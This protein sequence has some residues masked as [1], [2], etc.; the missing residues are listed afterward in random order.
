MKSKLSLIVLYLIVCVANGQESKFGKTSLKYGI[1]VGVAD[2]IQVTGD[3]GLFFCGLNQQIGSRD[4]FRFSPQLSLG[5][6]NSNWIT[7]V[8]DQSFYAIS[9]TPVFFADVLRYRAFSFTTGAGILVNNMR[10]LMGTG[11]Y[12]PG[13]RRQYYFSIWNYGIYLGGGLR[14]NAKKSRVAI[15]IFPFNFQFDNNQYF[16]SYLR[17]GIDVKLAK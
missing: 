15:E 9:L 16:Q 13:N 1:G 6:F 14:I 5:Y 12:P 7:D 17:L 2:N 4:R 10:G 8:P 3:G 11:G